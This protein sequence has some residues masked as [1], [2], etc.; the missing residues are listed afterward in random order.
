MCACFVCTRV[1]ATK[2]WLSADGSSQAPRPPEAEPRLSSFI[3][4]CA[5]AVRGVRWRAAVCVVAPQTLSSMG[6][7]H[8]ALQSAK[9]LTH[10]HTHI[11][12][13]SIWA[14]LF[15][16]LFFSFFLLHPTRT[17]VFVFY[18]EL[19]MSEFCPSLVVSL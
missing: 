1:R 9:T 8:K 12:A 13:E 10:T 4:D 5:P 17:N 15:F 6:N 19:I 16:V 11:Q 14:F 7:E 2:A 3:W 18:T